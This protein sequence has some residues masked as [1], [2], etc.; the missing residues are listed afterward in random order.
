MQVPPVTPGSTG[1]V[2]LQ[3]G[4]A[5]YLGHGHGAVADLVGSDDE[6]D[7]GA[8]PRD[9]LTGLYEAGGWHERESRGGARVRDLIKRGGLSYVISRTWGYVTVDCGVPNKFPA[10]SEQSILSGSVEFRLLLKCFMQGS[11]I[12]WHPGGWYKPYLPDFDLRRLPPELLEHVPALKVRV[13]EARTVLGILTISVDS[14]HFPCVI[15]VPTHPGCCVVRN[16]H[17]RRSRNAAF[18][19]H[20][21]YTRTTRLWRWFPEGVTPCGLV[22]FTVRGGRATQW[23]DSP[24]SGGIKAE[25]EL[26]I[27]TGPDARAPDLVASLPNLLREDDARRC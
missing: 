4:D 20:H 17:P 19:V 6:F 7:L 23:V 3:V 2:R 11:S 12:E 21:V 18:I 26:V 27:V 8:L 1:A 25:D 14:T 15:D 22:I 9:A 16:Y 5:T 24:N 10:V 13:N